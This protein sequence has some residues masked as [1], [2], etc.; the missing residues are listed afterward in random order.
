MIVSK[1]HLSRRTFLRGTGV[2]IGL[3]L[4]DAMIP[5]LTLQAKTSANPVRRLGFI[6][7]PH[8]AWMEKW[9]PSAVG[10]V[11]TLPASLSPLTPFLNHVV[12]PTNLEHANAKADG[13]AGGNAEHTRSN[14]V[15]L[16][17]TRPK[18]TEG[19]DVHL[20]KTVDQIAADYLSKETQLPSLELT[21]ESN[22]SVGNC[23]NGYN[24][25]YMNSMSWRTPT[26]PLPM[27]NNPRMVFERLFGEGGSAAELA[28]NRRADASLLDA[29]LDD[30]KRLERRLGATDR[31]TVTGY[32]DSVREVERRIQKA[33]ASNAADLTLPDRP[34]GV[35]E[36]FEEHA[37][38]L[39]DLL[40]LSFQADITRVFTFMLGR[41]LSARPFPE[42]GVNDGHHSVSHHQ[43]N[44]AKLAMIEKINTYHISFL[45]YLAEKLQGISD[46]GGSL[47][48]HSMILHGSG[49]GDGNLHDHKNLPLVVVGGGA[50]RQ[51]ARHVPYPE[52]SPMANVLVGML[53]KAG[54]DAERFG[55]STDCLDFDLL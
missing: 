27:E 54:I 46:G 37:K 18:M 51:G 15:W 38:L 12:V 22:F 14:A 39:M 50:G 26:Q 2:A 34:S 44:P 11:D 42:I 30:M 32:L 8:G 6:Y 40:T 28:A 33:E 36:R 35:P 43:N 24:C 13:K 1:K 9:T 52:L 23:D 17:A 5:A 3:P 19:T 45:A 10:R 55:D 31:G 7:I 4:L 53:H 21:V 48:D 16:S 47:L 25:V 20:A 41:E 29:I 49:M